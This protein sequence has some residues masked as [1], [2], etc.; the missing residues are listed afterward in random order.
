MK[1]EDEDNNEDDDEDDNISNNN[2]NS[3]GDDNRSSSKQPAAWHK[4]L[5]HLHLI[6]TITNKSNSILNIPLLFYSLHNLFRRCCLLLTRAVLEKRL[7]KF[8]ILSFGF[9][10]SQNPW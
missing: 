8:T 3:D 1:G 6:I 5:Y 10:F 7:C 4:A 9:R 2:S